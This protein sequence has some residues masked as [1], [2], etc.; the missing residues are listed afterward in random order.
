MEIL[1]KKEIESINKQRKKK[2]YLLQ[3]QKNVKYA[4][5]KVR[6]LC[7]YTGKFRGASHSIQDIVY[8]KKFQ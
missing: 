3:L 2:S 4:N 6:D 7:S 5:D 1:C 8:L